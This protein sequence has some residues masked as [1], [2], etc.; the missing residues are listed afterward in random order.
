[1]GELRLDRDWRFDSFQLLGRGYRHLRKNIA[2]NA[3]DSARSG[4]LIH[5]R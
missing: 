2:N 3:A 4:E 5:S 1:M